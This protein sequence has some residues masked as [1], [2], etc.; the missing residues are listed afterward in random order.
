L[1][2][3]GIHVMS[4]SITDTKHFSS[5]II[6]IH[7][8]SLHAPSQ[9]F[10][11][12]LLHPPSV[13]FFLISGRIAQML[14]DIFIVEPRTVA[15]LPLQTTDHA[16]LSSATTSHVVTAFFQLNHSGAIVA[17]LPSFLLSSLDELLRSR[18]FRTFSGFVGFAIADGADSRTTFLALP[19]LATMIVSNIL[20]T[21]PFATRSIDAIYPVLGRVLEVFAIESLL[22]VVVKKL[23]DVLEIDMVVCTTPWRH[24]RRVGDGHLE[25]APQ[26]RVA[27][28]VLT[29]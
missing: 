8:Q 5:W 29:W 17:F 20:W 27:H 12:S 26:A 4:G 21:D 3:V 7:A 9:L 18:V 19:N 23:V 15:R 1:D 13:H 2:E 16:E 11:S 22:E 14:I 25:D 28:A 6:L 10:V 24:V